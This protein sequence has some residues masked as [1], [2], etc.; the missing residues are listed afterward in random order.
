MFG[1]VRPYRDEG[2][3]GGGGQIQKSLRILTRRSKPPSI[4]IISRIRGDVEV[5]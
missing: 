1:G 5:R 4:V 2:K 3:S